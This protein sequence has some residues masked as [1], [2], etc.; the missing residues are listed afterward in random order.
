MKN[1][2]LLQKAIPSELYYHNKTLDVLF[3]RR[4]NVLSEKNMNELLLEISKDDFE[5]RYRIDRDEEG[6]CRQYFEVQYDIN[7]VSI[8]LNIEVKYLL[9]NGNVIF[10]KDIGIKYSLEDMICSFADGERT[11][12]FEER[13]KIRNEIEAKSQY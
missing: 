6:V 4:N 5:S 2:D 13:K 1:I 3:N 10:S 12:T 8:W 9:Y 11:E 7:E